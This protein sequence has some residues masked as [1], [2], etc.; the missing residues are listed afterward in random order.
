MREHEYSVLSVI[1]GL[2]FVERV[3][4]GCF[5]MSVIAPCFYL[6]MSYKAMV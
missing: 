3:G 2:G 5:Y 1:I 4:L 6:F